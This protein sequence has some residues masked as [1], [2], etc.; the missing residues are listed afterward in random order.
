MLKLLGFCLG[1]YL[2][3][4]VI[5]V[6]VF[7]TYG[8]YFAFPIHWGALIEAM[9]SYRLSLWPSGIAALLGF[10][11]AFAYFFR[12][13]AIGFVSSIFPIGSALIAFL[14]VG[15]IYAYASMKIDARRI[16]ATCMERKS[17]AEAARFSIQ[18]FRP[19]YAWAYNATSGIHLWSYHEMAFVPAPETK[20]PGR[21]PCMQDIENSAINGAAMG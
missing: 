18:E 9:W 7:G 20:S 16:E 13:N 6:T 12:R 4:V 8:I 15:E 17:F 3:W 1:T 5:V 19:W 14:L 2:Y 21:R 10:G 11:G